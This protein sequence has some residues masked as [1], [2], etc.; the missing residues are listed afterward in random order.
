MTRPAATSTLR[1]AEGIDDAARLREFANAPVF[2]VFQ[3]L[4]SSP[5]GLT[6]QDAAE[7]SAE[8]GPNR[9]GRYVDD[10]VAARV[11]A[12]IRNPFVALLTGLGAVFVALA[13]VRGAVTVAVMVSLAVGLRVWQQTRSVRAARALR[14]QVNTT[15]SV[16][17]RAAAGQTPVDREAPV[18]DLVPGDVVLLRPGD[19][20]PADVRL[21]TATDLRVDQ[22]TLSGES[23][24]V[25][26]LAPAAPGEAEAS[27][28]GVD[29]VSVCFAGTTVVS[30]TAT[31]VVIAT[32]AAT[33]RDGL[34][35]VAGNLRPDSSFDLGV[36]SVGLTLIR[37]ML[38]M[39]PIVLVVN[40]S[41]RGDWAQA[42][43]FAV[44]VAVG[45][46]PEMLPVIVTANLVRG[47]TRLARER[48]IVSRLEAI[49]DLGAMDV[50][51]VDKTGTLTEDR[52]VYAHSIDPTGRIDDSVGEIAYLAVHFQES[53][54]N[55]LD[56]AVLQ[57]LA[58]D[59]MGAVAAAAF[60][61]VDEIMFDHTR[62]RA[63]V[64][65]RRQAAEHI[66]ISRGDPDEIL[67]RCDRVRLGGDV[68]AFDEDIR[69]EAAG[70]VAAYGTR[71]M[72]VL[73][74][75]ARNGNARWERY[76][77]HDE[78][79][80]ILVGFLGFVD[81]VR[82]D[83]D[84]AIN[85]LDGHGVT[86]KILSGDSANVTREVASQVGLIA[87]AAVLGADIDTLSE[88]ELGETAE[89]A[90]V[91]AKLSPAHKARIVAALRARG[92]TVGFLGEGVN[93]VPALRAA[94][95]GIAAD[96]ATDAAK[97]A[98]DLILLTKS[99]PI[100]AHGVI[101]GRRTLAN[102][103]KYVKITASSNF[104]NVL[105]VLA[106]GVFLPFLPM[107]PIQLMV[108]NLLYD[109]AQLALPAD[110]VAD[111]YLRAPRRWSPAGL[112]RFMLWFGPLSS[113]FD[114]ATFGVLW[115]VFRAGDHPAPFHTGWF[116]EGLLTQLLAVLVLRAPTLPWRGARPSR[117]VLT[118][119]VVVAGI[120][121][122]LP[123][124]PLAAPLRLVA[125]PI[126]YLPW[127]AAATAT[128]GLAAHLVKKR[129][130]RR[131]HDWL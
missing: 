81:P 102:T 88:H 59:G 104:G 57:H 92:H 109:T 5:H 27:Q 123:L 42:A 106:A 84:A 55:G 14:E 73:A 107:L 29:T 44:A 120:G 100:L 91:F 78:C 83:A 89:R 25:R 58:G 126:G 26:K 72:R 8:Y 49:Q 21:L 60:D 80:L 86:V 112:V 77:E 98:A 10:G 28:L 54:Y 127:L 114:L 50:L 69:A 38:V 118:A 115:W 70:V 35:R 111:D 36:R 68:V 31:A 45:L 4:G 113:V 40:G 76:D 128:Y 11:W 22:A 116:I 6:E 74:V 24:P 3:R 125:P 20:V 65:V 56:E 47:A 101:E 71:G 130:L 2:T 12:A 122:L 64:I 19:V 124:P 97:N 62:R 121:C 34:A 7:R 52:V 108:Q 17:R 51:C 131:H 30:G 96:T 61:K 87:G 53:P 93:D 90:T 66:L 103:M 13:D 85:T 18:E 32:G 41:V 63:T 16:R 117:P 82:V 23:L 119:V 15:V 9:S 48:V 99:L 43:M 67:P 95:A 37:F 39:V 46:T 105:T 129:Y 1:P 33:Y 110:R 75:A 79:G 94:D